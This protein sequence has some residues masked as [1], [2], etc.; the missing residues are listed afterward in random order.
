[1]IN[2]FDNAIILVI[3]SFAGRSYLFDAWNLSVSA[4]PLFKGALF[5]SIIWWYWFRTGD[6]GIV[7][8]TREHLLCTIV[9][10]TFSLGCASPGAFIAISCPTALRSASSLSRGGR[11]FQRLSRLEF[12]PERPRRALCRARSRSWLHVPRFWRISIPL[13]SAGNCLSSNLLGVS[14]SD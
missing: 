7:R 14:L 4:N 1:M 9:A 13:F 6:L 12:I 5:V 2:R 3:N 10:G 8:R 11:T